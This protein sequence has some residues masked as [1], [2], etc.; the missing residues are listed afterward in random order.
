MEKKNEKG[1][2][3]SCHPK[4]QGPLGAGYLIKYLFLST[5][6]IL[7]RMMG[8]WYPEQVKRQVRRPWGFALLNSWFPANYKSL[9]SWTL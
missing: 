4:D 9:D 7:Q 8:R 6:I 2:E 3:V 1:M 5:E